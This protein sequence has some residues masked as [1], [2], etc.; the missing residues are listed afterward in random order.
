MCVCCV[1]IVFT[2]NPFVTYNINTKLK[3]RERRLSSSKLGDRRLFMINLSELS[4]LVVDDTRIN[5]DLLVLLLQK[6]NY[7]VRVA[8]SGIEALQKIA[9]NPPDLILLDIMMPEMDGYETCLR[10]KRNPESKDIP[11]IFITALNEI[12]DKMKGFEVGGIDYITKPFEVR[13]VLARVKAQL[14]IQ[15]LNKTL[16]AKNRELEKALEEVKSLQGI[17]PICSKCKKIR[18]DDGFWQRVEK[19]V[20]ERTGAK[21]SH[22][23]CP[24][25]LKSEIDKLDKF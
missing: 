21:F 18:D 17:V 16:A 2:F 25:C 19:Y 10:I 9:R 15:H 5:V 8:E 7:N 3:I 1:L 20:S 11:V 13:E 6:E 22:S 4:V 12:A 23:Y 24:S 14:T